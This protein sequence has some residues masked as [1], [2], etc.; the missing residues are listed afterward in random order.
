LI[1]ENYLINTFSNKL[2]E[3]RRKKRKKEKTKKIKVV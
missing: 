2:R 3:K 1:I